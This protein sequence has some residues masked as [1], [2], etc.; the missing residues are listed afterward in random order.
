MEANRLGELQRL[1]RA[2]HI[3]PF[4]NHKELHAEGTHVI[5][6]GSGCW[7]TDARGRKLLDGLAGLWCVNV[8]Y[9]RAE[10]ADAVREQM[11]RLPY[12]CSFL[13]STTELCAPSRRA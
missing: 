9:G 6:S 4:T 3:H 11:M 2:H 1:D 5:A 10:I 8:G 13:N 12:Y 7:V